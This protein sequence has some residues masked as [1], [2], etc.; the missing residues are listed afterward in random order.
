MSFVILAHPVR[1][2]VPEMTCFCGQ[3]VSQEHQAAMAADPAKLETISLSGAK[4]GWLASAMG[5][6]QS[7]H[8]AWGSRR[9]SDCPIKCDTQ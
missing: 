1:A 3:V 2:L 4:Q 8:L 7:F 6:P 5:R 9:T